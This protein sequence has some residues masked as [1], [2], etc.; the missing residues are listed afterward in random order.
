MTDFDGKYGFGK[1]DHKF[2]ADAFILNPPYSANGNGMNFCRTCARHDEK[3]YAAIIIQIP[4][5]QEKPAKSTGGFS[6]K[7]TLLA[8]YQNALGFVY[9]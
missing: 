5:A 3:G 1:T 4:Q 9:R 6:Q 2:P 7:N 8:K